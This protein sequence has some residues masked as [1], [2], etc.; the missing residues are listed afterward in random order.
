MFDLMVVSRFPDALRNHTK[1]NKIKPWK[2]VV[3]RVESS[4]RGPAR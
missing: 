3:S 1:T 4:N 2:T